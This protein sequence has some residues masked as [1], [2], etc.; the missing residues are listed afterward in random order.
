MRK[1]KNCALMSRA[2]TRT[3]EKTN[4]VAGRQRRRGKKTGERV[5]KERKE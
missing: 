4:A 1:R 2:Q 5:N 3:K